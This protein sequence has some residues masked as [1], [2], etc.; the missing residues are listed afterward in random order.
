[1]ISSPGDYDRADKHWFTTSSRWEFSKAA[2]TRSLSASCL[3]TVQ[4]KP[5]R[6]QSG[7]WDPMSSWKH[8]TLRHIITVAMVP[9]AVLRLPSAPQSCC[10]KAEPVCHHS[11]PASWPW[12]SSRELL[13]RCNARNPRFPPLFRVLRQISDS[14]RAQIAWGDV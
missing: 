1:M 3:L 6:N 12:F 11:Y 10:L 9:K 7:H 4:K 13:R 14:L 8:F 2:A 5:T